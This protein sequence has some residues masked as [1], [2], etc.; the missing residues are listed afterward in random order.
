[1]GRPLDLVFDVRTDGADVSD[2]CVTA[3]VTAGDTSISQS[4]ITV[5]PQPKTAGRSASVRLRSSQPINE[6][7]LSVR[8]SAGCSGSV[9][10]TYTVLAYPAEAISAAQMRAERARAAQAPLVLR[11]TLTSAAAG[12]PEGVS[13]R[14]EVPSAQAPAQRQARAE[15]P[16][17]PAVTAKPEQDT[18]RPRLVMEPLSDWLEAPS[19]LRASTEIAAV[20]E[21][22]SPS[23][24]EQAAARWRAL[25]MQPEDLLQEQA[26]SAAQDKAQSEQLAA[27]ERD[28]AA[29]VA[30][31]QQL[32]ERA[33]ERFPAIVV[34][35]LLALLVALTA[36][37]VWVWGRKPRAP[38]E[39][40]AAWARGPVKAAAP[41]AALAARQAEEDHDVTSRPQPAEPEMLPSGMMP[42]EFGT[43][44]AA[45]EPAEDASSVAAQPAAS[46]ASAV[47]AV[48]AVLNPEDLF[49][50]QQQAE[51]FVSVGEHDQAIEVMKK[52]IEANQSTSP[53][54]YLEL[55]RLY[56]SLS[57]IEQFNEL[58]AQ[59][60][61]Y[62]NAQVPEFA[63]FARPGRNLFGYPD[64]LARIEALWCD[65]SVVPLL[66]E[67]LFRGGGQG[68]RFDLPAY[69]DL[70]LLHAVA[71]TTP[72]SAR[73]Q[74]APRSRTTPSEAAPAE[75]GLPV[76]APAPAAPSNLMEFEPDWDFDAQA[77]AAAAPAPTPV[78]PMEIDLDLS[79]L[80]HLDAL[81]DSAE[82]SRPL[83]FLTQQKVPAVAST[84]P[85]APDQPVGFGVNSD[86]FEAR[87]D[88]DER[89]PR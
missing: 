8:L 16:P 81:A 55:L 3:G 14:S 56:R 27:A 82:T 17:R 58:R 72:A 24:R 34:Y 78:A 79:D 39:R 18:G 63:A 75:E 5:T 21:S 7:V 88:P 37:L 40:E 30:L 52:H 53:S 86:R 22:V 48:T 47:P 33:A 70:L 84:P 73:G 87:V 32:Q 67:L 89:K 46:A 80:T 60:H 19:V 45:A 51:F 10:R 71:R 65:P 4:Q 23:L 35:V 44:E 41:A 42:L 28:K 1:M 15:R 9:V 50:L 26:R 83:P 69:D 29:A 43:S 31:Q 49:D 38:V 13:R 64:V 12:L 66:Q 85:P 61:R 76:A 20:P 57:R 68:Q 25:N 77:A 62:F 11:S 6:P 59:F 74:S 54:A 2:A 36:L